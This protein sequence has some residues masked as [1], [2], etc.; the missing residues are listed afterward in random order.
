MVGTIIMRL[1]STKAD[2]ELNEFINRANNQ[3][4]NATDKANKSMRYIRS[5]ISDTMHGINVGFRLLGALNEQTKELAWYQY[6]QIGLSVV[7]A[8]WSVGMIGYRAT[9]AFL[10]GDVVRGAALSALAVGMQALASEAIHNR[11]MALENKHRIEGIKKY[12]GAYR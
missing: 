2:Q 9:Q 7:E 5:A 8:E 4:Q 6:T 1:D 10:A 11:V 12:M 3:T